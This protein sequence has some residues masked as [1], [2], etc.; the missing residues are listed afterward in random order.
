MIMKQPELNT[1]RLQLRLGITD[2]IPAIL[3]Y[4]RV[5]RAY[6]APFEPQRP[7]SQYGD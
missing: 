5:N 4:Y 6:L 7:A 3:H 2:D 1:A